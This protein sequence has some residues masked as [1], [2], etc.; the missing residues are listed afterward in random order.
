MELGYMTTL[1]T[2]I[3][4]EVAVGFDRTRLERLLNME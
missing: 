3:D 4:G 1:V 2:T